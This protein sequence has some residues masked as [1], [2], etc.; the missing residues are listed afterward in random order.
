[1]TKHMAALAA[2]VLMTVCAGAA[3][4]AIGGAALFHQSGVMAASSPAQSSK[5]TDASMVQQSQADQ[6]QVQQLQAQISQYQAREQQYQQELGQAQAA[7]QQAQGQAQQQ[8]QEMQQ[9]L[10]VLQQRGLITIN[11][12]GSITI[13]R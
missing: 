7:A 8:L 4:F 9:L 11:G 6:A 12:D 13:N 1:M 10:F 3:V 2:A 5:A